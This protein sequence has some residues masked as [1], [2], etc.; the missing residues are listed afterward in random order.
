[1]S[2]DL[3]MLFLW[4]SGRAASSLQRRHHSSSDAPPLLA[5]PQVA[6]G[7]LLIQNVLAAIL[8]VLQRNQPAAK[9]GDERVRPAQV[10]FTS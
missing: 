7:L 6:Q 10:E 4:R 2:V 5:N 1:M 8:V 9:L 3:M